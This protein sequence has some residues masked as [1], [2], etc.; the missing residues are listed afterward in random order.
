MHNPLHSATTETSN[1]VAETTH[2]ELLRRWHAN[3][4]NLRRANRAMQREVSI[5]G[6]E[7][8]ETIEHICIAYER[9]Q[10]AKSLAEEKGHSFARVW[11][12]TKV[13]RRAWDDGDLMP[14]PEQQRERAFVD[15]GFR[16]PPAVREAVRS[17]YQA[18]ASVS[19]LA[20]EHHLSPWTVRSILKAHPSV[21]TR[22]RDRGGREK[23]PFTPEQAQIRAEYLAGGKIIDIA[24]R[25]QTY[26]QRVRYI[27]D[28]PPSAIAERDNIPSSPQ[29]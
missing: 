3:P 8:E 7:R 22:D 6:P 11:E 25:H 13:V 5:V 4:E 28:K 2:V 15:S 9:G 29:S 27:L 19:L 18:G 20:V 1:A 10:T 23:Q 16:T 17:A 21:F 24:R 12:W 26:P 14:T